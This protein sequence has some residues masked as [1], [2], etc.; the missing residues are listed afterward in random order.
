MRSGSRAFLFPGTL[1]LLSLAACGE[2]P[3]PSA[4]DGELRQAAP[5]ATPAT[6]TPAYPAIA[7][8]IVYREYVSQNP[9]LRYL[10]S[11]DPR[12]QRYMEKRL[13]ELYPERGYAGMMKD[14]VAEF[15]AFRDGARGSSQGGGAG[16]QSCETV[17]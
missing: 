13:R 4:A 14:A 17:M 11:D 6:R 9:G 1:L 8:Y 10:D 16:V 12:Y 5:L 15:R 7:V 3:L 2:G